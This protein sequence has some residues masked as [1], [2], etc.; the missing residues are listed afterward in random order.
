VTPGRRGVR[1]EGIHGLRTWGVGAACLLA[2]VSVQCRPERAPT[3]DPEPSTSRPATPAGFDL[4]SGLAGLAPRGFAPDGPSQTL[5]E[6]ALET[7][8]DDLDSF[9]TNAGLRYAVCQRYSATDGPAR[10]F[11]ACVYVHRAARAAM[12]TF[13]SIS[14]A[15]PLFGRDEGRPSRLARHAWESS[16]F[17]AFVQGDAYVEVASEETAA[18]NADARTEVA[19]TLAARYGGATLE[20]PPFPDGDRVNGK[21]RLIM[22][23]AFGASGLDGIYACDYE[24]GGNEAIAFW[25]DRDS[26]DEAEALARRWRDFLL[27][28]GA[29]QGGETMVDATVLSLMGFT[30]VVCTRGRV[31]AG[32]HQAESLELARRLAAAVCAPPG[33]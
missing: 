18:E 20:P 3:R 26:A 2:L 25:S 30:E 7:K 16:G 10:R 9:Y 27:A 17:L 28:N 14:Q 13:L 8:F 1:R 12:S 15:G 5:D 22:R 11:D 31:F 21:L 19:A 33:T 6:D 23:N 4:A 29:V 32:V 24:A